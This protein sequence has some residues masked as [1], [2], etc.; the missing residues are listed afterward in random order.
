MKIEKKHYEFFSQLIFKLSGMAY[1]EKDFYRLDGRLNS[2]AK[3]YK[4]ENLDELIK[5]FNNPDQDKIKELINEATNNETYFFRDKKP[6]EFLT[7][8]FLP[9]LVERKPS[10]PV[11]FWS[12]ACSSGQEVYSTLMSLHDKFPE[13]AKRLSFKATDISAEIL[14]KA[15]KGN[16]TNLEIQRGLPIKKL[17]KYFKNQE[18]SSWTF[19]DEYR[20]GVTYSEFN[21]L[22]PNFPLEKF[23]VVFCRNVLIYQNQENKNLI[24][25]KIYECLSEGGILILG[26]GESLLGIDHKFKH[27]T[28][29]GYTVFQRLDSLSDVA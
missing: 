14:E 8:S 16:Y 10:G 1:E 5:L 2:L 13:I 27:F 3:K 26:A 15:R 28:V 11:Y 18:D 7:E 9:Q 24:L 20:K 4:V 22:S 19:K 21:L 12:C 25:N 23:D 17:M 6:F 29:N